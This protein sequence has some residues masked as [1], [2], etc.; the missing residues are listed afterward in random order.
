[1]KRRVEVK[2]MLCDVI[3][4][5]TLTDYCLIEIVHVTNLLTTY[6]MSK[7]YST[8]LKWEKLRK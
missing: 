8:Y 3:N 7:Q 4:S 1:M 5:N 2:E 6:H